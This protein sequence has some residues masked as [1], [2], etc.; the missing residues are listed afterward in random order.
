MRIWDGKELEGIP[1]E[2]EIVVEPLERI[3]DGV[4]LHFSHDH[5]L[6]L[7]I[8]GAYHV[9]KFCQAC[10]LPIY[11]GSYYSCMDQCDF[12]LHEACANAPCKKQHAI[13]AHSLTLRVDNI[14]FWSDLGYFYCRA[15]G[16][17]STGFAY[18]D[19]KDHN[20]FQL[21]L[22]CASV[23]EPFQYQGHEHPLFLALMPEE[24]EL[25]ICQICQEEGEKDNG[26]RKLLTCIE[27][28]YIICFKCATL[29]YKA[30]Y[31]YDNH[32]L[33]FRKKE[34]GNDHHGWCEICESKIVFSRKGGFYSCDDYCST[35][36]HV[37]CLLGK[38]PYMDVVILHNKTMSRPLCH[39]T[40]H[41][42]QDK[43]VFKK[44]NMTFCSLRC[45]QRYNV[46][47]SR[48]PN[49][50]VSRSTTYLRR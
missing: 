22:R 34:E 1:E 17:P 41:R 2:P 24:E 37:D 38:Y 48:F 49:L 25:E 15:C 33:I 18:E 32:F 28:K 44:E 35:T 46:I 14:G 29:P 7:E 50:S 5:R 6:K 13:H 39:G 23:S 3:S 42:C 27:C 26:Q 43:V 47:L 31:K 21:D 30:R 45:I 11:E 40:E 9:E 20:G 36:V 19:P 8:S 4:I 12:I 16:R 10:S